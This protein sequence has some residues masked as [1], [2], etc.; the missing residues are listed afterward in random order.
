M[1]FLPQL[2]N[3]VLPIQLPG[4]QRLD[5]FCLLEDNSRALRLSPETLSHQRLKQKLLVSSLCEREIKACWCYTGQ[6]PLGAVEDCC[7]GICFQQLSGFHVSSPCFGLWTC[8]PWVIFPP[9]VGLIL[10]WA[11]LA[12]ARVHL[13]SSLGL[14]GVKVSV[15]SVFHDHWLC[16]G[17]IRRQCLLT[18]AR[19]PCPRRRRSLQEVVGR[20]ARWLTHF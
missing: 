13:E 4:V 7:G 3:E 2:R 1:S 12:S 17:N 15:F 10:K 8:E 11:V 9:V 20:L 16:Q 6:G 18:K 19:H 14:I 5:S